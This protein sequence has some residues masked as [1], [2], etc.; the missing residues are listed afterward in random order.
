VAASIHIDVQ[1]LVLDLVEELVS[2]IKVI[3]VFGT[4]ITVEN[5]L[6]DLVPDLTKLKQEVA[7][8]EIKETIIV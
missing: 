6:G 1:L 8:H 3:V 5:V 7:W 2:A 4:R